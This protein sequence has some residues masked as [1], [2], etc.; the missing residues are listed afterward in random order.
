MTILTIQQILMHGVFSGIT[1]AARSSFIKS[2]NECWCTHQQEWSVSTTVG[3]L[4]IPHPHQA[5]LGLMSEEGVQQLKVCA[6]CEFLMTEYRALTVVA[7][8]IMST[9][10]TACIDKHSHDWFAIV[11]SDTLGR[12]QTALM[13]AY[14]VLLGATLTS[15]NVW[16]YFMKSVQRPSLLPKDSAEFRGW[17][18]TLPQTQPK[19]SKVHQVWRKAL[20]QM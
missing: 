8:I 5:L 20:Q 13:T 1:F 15:D 18:D 9:Q 7:R 14:S 19:E 12:E 4:A 16:R 2:N 10:P 3:A 6:F 17:H 11:C